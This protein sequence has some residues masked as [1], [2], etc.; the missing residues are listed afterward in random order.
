MRAVG[1]IISR[2]NGGDGQEQWLTGFENH[3]G[4]TRLGPVRSRLPRWKSD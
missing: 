2:W 1:E 3:G 4:Y